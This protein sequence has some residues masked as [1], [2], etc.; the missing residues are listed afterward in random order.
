MASLSALVVACVALFTLQ[1][2]GV[3]AEAPKLR[4]AAIYLV[5]PPD[6]DPDNMNFEKDAAVSIRCTWKY[7]IKAHGYDIVVFHTMEPGALEAFQ[8][9]VGPLAR[10]WHVK[11][12]RIH[13][14]FPDGINER[15]LGEEGRC[16]DPS[17]GIDMWREYKSCGC[18]CPE[19]RIVNRTRIINGVGGLHCWDI[20]YLHMNRF[21]THNIWQHLADYDYYMRVDA[22]LFLQR[23]VTDPFRKMADDKTVFAVGYPEGDVQGCF[24]G[25]QQAVKEWAQ[26]VAPKLG[27]TAYPD[28]LD[29]VP[30]WQ[31]Y[32][33]GFHAGSVKFF[34]SPAHMSLAKHINENGGIYTRRWSDQV[35]FPNA[36]GV[37]FPGGREAGTSLV[38]F[39]KH[40]CPGVHCDAGN[41]KHVFA[42]EHNAP[43]TN[44]G[45]ADQCEL[46]HDEL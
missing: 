26:S 11:F 28:Q 25:Q 2:C 17:N 1:R 7:F 5:A 4:G 9:L 38:P 18:T 43:R 30:F 21:F 3:A 10:N 33:G 45:I 20:N 36:V 6:N 19:L 41:P 39:F 14:D 16:V 24:E 32:W 15:W 13:F 46:S 31:C 8:D 22:D 42:H 37:L 35:H 34:R 40:E 23:H 12:V 27:L 29:D 44:T